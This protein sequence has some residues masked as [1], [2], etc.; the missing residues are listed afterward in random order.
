MN[1][2]ELSSNVKTRNLK[3]LLWGESGARKTETILRNFPHVFLIDTEGNSDQCICMPEIKPFLRLVTKDVYEIL[4]ALDDIAAGNVKFPDGSPVETVGRDGA[5]VIW[6]VRSE[7]GS[8]AAEERAKR[9][10]AKKGP[11]DVSMTFA[12]WNLA[13]KPL[14]RLKARLGGMGIGV[15]YVIFTARSKDEYEKR[16]GAT[17]DQDMIKVGTTVDAMKGLSYEMNIAFE[18][19]AENKRKNQAWER[20][21]SKVQGE[22]GKMFPMGSAMR[23]FPTSE[24]I[25]YAKGSSEMAPDETEV[26]R[27]NLAR[28]EHSQSDLLVLAREKGMDAKQVGAALKRDG[29][30]KFDAA[31]W[32]DMVAALEAEK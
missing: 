14:K 3:M 18:F 21:V 26:A 2:Y 10:S 16:P 32:D 5:T 28:E 15:K 17:S 4:D 29:I 23:E 19:V 20:R 8:L 27:Q 1:K 11:D 6:S 12:D 13:K 31:K 7:V 24:L 30:E 25:A 22:L 9:F